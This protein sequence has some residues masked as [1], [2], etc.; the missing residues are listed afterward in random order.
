MSTKSIKKSSKASTGSP[1][2]YSQSSRKGKKAWRKNIDIEDIE[3]TMEELRAEERE[4][5]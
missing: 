5:G 2:Q 3:A 4:T 1:A